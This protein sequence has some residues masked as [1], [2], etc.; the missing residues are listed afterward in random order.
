MAKKAGKA[1]DD[2]LL[3]DID[4]SGGWEEHD[5]AELSQEFDV[6]ADPDDVGVPNNVDDTPDVEVKKVAKAPK[7]EEEDL[8]E[9]EEEPEDEPQEDEDEDEDEDPDELEDQEPGGDFLSPWEKKNYSK[10]MAG[11]VS[12]ERRLKREAEDHSAS[13]DEE[14]SALRERT[15]KAEKLALDLLVDKVESDIAAIKAGIIAAKEEGDTAGE[16]EA[17]T[18]L[19]ELL[20][21]KREIERSN[22]A[23]TKTAAKP[24]TTTTANGDKKPVSQQTPQ[25]KRWVERNRWFTN[26]EFSDE[27][28]FARSIDAGIMKDPAFSN[29]AGSSAYFAEL[30]RRLHEK[31][32]HLRSKIRKV[33]GTK[34]AQRTAPVGRG[35]T[36]NRSSSNNNPKKV[37]LT[38]ADIE[39]ARSFGITSQEDLRAYAANKYKRENEERQRGR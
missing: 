28:G 14:L 22:D 15:S 19:Q 21:K 37:T 11:R 20:I 32:P 12:R 7:E 27:E 30:D 1:A 33:F 18:K 23:I 2:D 31:M 8:L 17:S 24:A 36:Q 10:A 26:P 5:P 25:L 6:S 39:N 3:A 13:K 38:A 9:E 4:D 35:T 34:P 29:Q 16:V